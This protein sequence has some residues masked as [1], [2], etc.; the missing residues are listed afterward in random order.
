MTKKNWFLISLAVVLAATYLV[1]FVNWKPQTV[2][3]FH[4]IR[5]M[6]HRPMPAG[7]MSGLIFGLSR[8]LKL[9]DIKVVPLA[10]YETNKN[11][12]P[13]WHLT[14]SSNSI[15]V[16]S[17][18]YGQHIR[19]LKPAVP[20]TRPQLLEPNTAYRMFVEAGEV[21]GTHDFELK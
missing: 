16:K 18:F 5:M 1:F 12:L 2:Q 4:T 3:I 10:E 15:P 17:F 6:R 9:T 20:G 7:E 21:K 11:V 8:Q 14:T 19:G 13:V